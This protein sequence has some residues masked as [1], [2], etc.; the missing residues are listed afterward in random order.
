MN[1]NEN[2]ESD[3]K[4]MLLQRSIVFFLQ[5][6]LLDSVKRDKNGEG[7][8]LSFSERNS[9]NQN[10][11]DN[12]LVLTI[13]DQ[14]CNIN[15]HTV[16]LLQKDKRLMFF[17]MTSRSQGIMIDLMNQCI[18]CAGE[19]TAQ[20]IPKCVV[21][22]QDRKD[23]SSSIFDNR[24]EGISEDL[25]DLLYTNN[26]LSLFFG[27]KSVEEIQKTCLL[28][29]N[30]K[31]I[32]FYLVPINA[33]DFELNVSIYIYELISTLSSES[34]IPFDFYIGT[35]N[36]TKQEFG[37][38]MASASFSGYPNRGQTIMNSCY[39]GKF[40]SDNSNESCYCSI[41][42]KLNHYTGYSI[43]GLSQG[44]GKYSGRNCTIGYMKKGQPSF[45]SIYSYLDCHIGSPS[46]NIQRIGFDIINN[47]ITYF[48]Q[49]KNGKRN[50][51]GLM[52]MSNGSV[53]AGYWRNNILDGIVLDFSIVGT[54]Y[55][56]Y[57]KG[58]E[59]YKYGEMYYRNQS[60][61]NGCW[62][63]SQYDK[64]GVLFLKRPHESILHCII[65]SWDFG[66]EDREIFNSFSNNQHRNILSN[67]VKNHHESYN[68][69]SSSKCCEMQSKDKDNMKDIYK[70][71]IKEWIEMDIHR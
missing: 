45:C 68:S 31:N 39:E 58:K 11:E 38:K 15:L 10:Y 21:F 33:N 40:Q 71:F 54:V 17:L 63:Q 49:F 20:R 16:Y 4:D 9:K 51:N 64:Y 19:I 55:N 34:I 56:G 1:S 41:H 23:S 50:G 27:V 52:M 35:F 48:G 2:Y 30:D 28:S 53:I 12:A 69:S 66:G 67:F 44:Y 42:K 59:F 14:S 22:I 57:L 26:V 37:I 70:G 25:Y 65:K 5:L 29:M 8:S 13:D 7:N 32:Y 18:Q 60:Y 24:I 46:R 43:N 61:Y 62:S 6:T 36:G 3:M 47:Q